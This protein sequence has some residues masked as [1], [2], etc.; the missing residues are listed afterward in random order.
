MVQM[1]VMGLQELLVHLEHQLKVHL[2]QAVH[3][4]QVEV[5][6]LLGQVEVVELLEQAE[7]VLM[8]LPEQVVQAAHLGQVEVMVLLVQVVLMELLEHLVHRVKMEHILVHLELL[9]HLV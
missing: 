6:V 9:V 1:V 3:L 4:G 8:E 5:M 7:L 2:V